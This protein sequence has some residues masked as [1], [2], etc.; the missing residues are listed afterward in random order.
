ME[1]EWNPDKADISFPE[2]STVFEDALWHSNK[3]VEADLLAG[4]CL[5]YCLP[6]SALL[7]RPSPP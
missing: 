2:A 6:R 1:F 4:N 3:P 7:D 5:H